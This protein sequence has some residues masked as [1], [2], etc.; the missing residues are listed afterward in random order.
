MTEEAHPAQPRKSNRGPA[1]GPENRRA[2]IK[3]ARAEFTANGA[4]VA[5]SRIAK[6]AGVGQG[7]LYR[8]FPDRTALVTAVFEDNLA[9]IDSKI[10][11]SDYPYRALMDAIEAQAAEAAA[12]IDV[13]AEDDPAQPSAQAL[14]ARLAK[15]ISSVREAAITVGELPPETT[16]EDLA[17]AVRMLALPLSKTPPA[18]RSATAAHIRRLLASGVGATP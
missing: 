16:E 11:S 8:H 3:A 5:L 10:E 7:S 14:R 9:V 6:R 18:E 13:V 4:Q 17:I 12:V 1:A 2:L 15:L